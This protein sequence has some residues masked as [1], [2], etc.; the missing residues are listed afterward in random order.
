M[1]AKYALQSFSIL[2]YFK[3]M[4]SKLEHYILQ[5]CIIR[6]SQSGS[7]EHRYAS[8]LF[9]D[10]TQF[11]LT[12]SRTKKIIIKTEQSFKP[13]L[14]HF[15]ERSRATQSSFI[16]MLELETLLSRKVCTLMLVKCFFFFMFVLFRRFLHLKS[17]MGM[18]MQIVSRNVSIYGR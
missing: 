10:K 17:L 2:K 8:L 16:K 5:N 18:N 3:E 6:Y 14:I 1:Q 12:N 7:T 15:Y 11:Y 13:Q 4:I 9:K